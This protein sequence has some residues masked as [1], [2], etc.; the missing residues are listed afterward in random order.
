MEGRANEIVNTEGKNKE[1]L[2]G[3]K[4]LRNEKA[5]DQKDKNIREEIEES[6]SIFY[7]RINWYT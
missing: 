7:I 1:N 5:K 2:L 6:K 3:N 4:R